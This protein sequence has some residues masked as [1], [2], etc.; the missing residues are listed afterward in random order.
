MSQLFHR[1]FIVTTEVGT[2]SYLSIQRVRYVQIKFVSYS[3]NL[4]TTFYQF[5][6]E[7]LIEVIILCDVV[8]QR[9]RIIIWCYNEIARDD[10]FIE[11]F[12]YF[13]LK[14]K[15][16]WP[17]SEFLVTAL[18]NFGL[19]CI[20]VCSNTDIYDN[21]RISLS[22]VCQFIINCHGC[23]LSVF[24]IRHIP[25]YNLYVVQKSGPSFNLPKAASLHLSQI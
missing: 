5:R 7:G 4:I 11:T 22:L 14:S 13:N 3:P 2:L 20:S 1:G 8:Q 16:L 18:S 24:P 21:R 25:K 19:R 15:S 6:I 10:I 17:F 12:L 23:S 9:L